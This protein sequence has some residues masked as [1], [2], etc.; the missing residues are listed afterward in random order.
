MKQLMLALHNYHDAYGYFPTDSR[1]KDGKP[2][3]SWRVHILPYIEQDGL[4]KRFKLDEPWDGPNNR[5]LLQSMPSVY[6]LP[7][8]Q[9]KTSAGFTHYRGFSSP[10]AVFDRRLVI[11]RK[12]PA[13]EM[14]ITGK[15]K[16]GVLDT[17]LV[18]EA[19]DSV[20]WTR[21][22]DL[23]ASPG[24]PAPRMGGFYRKNRFQILLGDG[25][26]RAVRQDLPETTIRALATHSAGDSLPVG[27]DQDP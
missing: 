12:R 18:V 17:A 15:F 1:D 9:G 16:D 25:S 13:D 19:A 5:L 27:W 14:L 21:P 22:D 6:I 2:L 20:E 10:G 7:T 11:N 26:V 3:L 24:K 8:A 23:D 4:Y